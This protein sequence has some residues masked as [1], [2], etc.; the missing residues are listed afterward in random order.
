[1]LK[2]CTPLPSSG[3]KSKPRKNQ[4]KLVAIEP[5]PVSAR[6][7]NPEDGDDKFL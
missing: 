4:Q 5:L 7:F 3:P 2:R 1:M 6:Y